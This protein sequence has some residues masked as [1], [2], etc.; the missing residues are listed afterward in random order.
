M[1]PSEC[2]PQL[3][4]LSICGPFECASRGQVICLPWPPTQSKPLCTNTAHKTLYLSA[5]QSSVAADDSPSCHRQ[6]LGA[7]Y[8]VLLVPGRPAITW[9]LL[10]PLPGPTTEAGWV[11]IQFAHRTMWLA[12]RFLDHPGRAPCPRP[13]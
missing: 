4:L 13:T 12:S 10:P 8:P 2:V 7:I 6:P 3:S 1:S 11:E 9:L 5:T